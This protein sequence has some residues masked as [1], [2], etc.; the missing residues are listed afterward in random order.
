MAFALLQVAECQLGELMTTEPTGQQEGK[1][2]P[3]TFA[4]QPLAVW[5][6]AECLPLFGGQPVAEPDAQLLYALDAPYSRGQVAAEQPAVCRLVRKT[7]HCSETEVDGTW[8]EM[9]GFEV[10]PVA[11]DHS[12]A[13]RQSR[14]RAVPVHEFVNG[15][16]ISALSVRLAWERLEWG[17]L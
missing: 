14:L 4:L 10:H 6:L 2:R 1:Q 3:I 8:S 9:A 16:P 13:K 11:D 15:V 5:C 12:L 17:P 7:P